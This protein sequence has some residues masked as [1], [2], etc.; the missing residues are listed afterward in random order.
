MTN[1]EPT[2]VPEDALRRQVGTNVQDGASTAGV[3]L[4]TPS[5]SPPPISVI[6]PVYRNGSHLTR[7]LESLQAAQ[8]QNF[9]V[10]L[11]DDASPEPIRD[12]LGWQKVQC[13]RLETNRGP[14]AAINHGL[15]KT[16]GDWVIVLNSDV[17][18]R[19][20]SL[21]R[22][23][24]ALEERPECGFAVAKLLS[25]K[26]EHTLDSA[27]D[28][29]LIGGGGYRIGHGELDRAQYN[30]VRSI[31]SGA[32]TAKA[33]RRSLLEE[34]GG[35]DEDFYGFLEDVDLSLRA[36]LRGYSC[37]YVPSAVVSHQG[38]ATF[39]ARGPKEIFRLITRNQI[40]LVAK[41]YPSTVLLRAL[42]RIVLF[43]VLWL[44]LMSSRGLLGAYLPGVWQ[45]LCGLPSMLRKRRE[46]QRSR[47]ITA[48][49][50]W[51]LLKESEREIAAWQE[52]LA[53]GQRSL[54]LRTYFRFLGWPAKKQTRADASA[55]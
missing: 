46:I 40:W 47:K 17:L 9:T 53:Q 39:N 19:P 41:N 34:V 12:G 48:G 8:E 29:L 54:L 32:G 18:V 1:G 45:A 10:V 14:S 51:E 43:Q 30:T 13:H 50:F 28:G 42:P 15:K 55:K 4:R 24:S 5:D 49:Q 21:N 16:T 25:Q 38:G 35:L 22:L 7:C 26:D 33:Y 37:L 20:D 36:Q 2:Q 44:A 27:G 31:L 52:R 11:V 23:I 6:I 3:S